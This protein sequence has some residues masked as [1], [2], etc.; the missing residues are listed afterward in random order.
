M[1]IDKKGRLQASSIIN[2]EPN[3]ASIDKALEKLFSSE[4]N[5]I[6]QETTNPYG[7]GGSSRKIFDVLKDISLKNII[8]KEFI[9]L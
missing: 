8:Q 1:A 6:L 7:I 3:E 2:C 5:L 4:F 9:D